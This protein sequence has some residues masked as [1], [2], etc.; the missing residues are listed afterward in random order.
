MKAVKSA[1]SPHGSRSLPY[2]TCGKEADKHIRKRLHVAFH[3]KVVRSRHNDRVEAIYQLF[4][5]RDPRLRIVTGEK[6]L[7]TGYGC[8][9]GLHRPIK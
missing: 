8:N 6:T 3:M 4:D 9:R 1:R 5:S 7:V 2:D